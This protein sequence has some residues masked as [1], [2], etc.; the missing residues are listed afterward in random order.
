MLK[1]VSVSEWHKTTA[2]QAPGTTANAKS[3]HLRF[4]GCWWGRKDGNLDTGTKYWI[5][6]HR[7]EKISDCQQQ[8]V[9]INPIDV[10]DFNPFFI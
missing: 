5:L 3:V 4:H 1:K 10:W 2:E 9:S 6:K 7:A 8:M